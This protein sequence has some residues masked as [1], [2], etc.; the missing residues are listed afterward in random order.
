VRILLGF[1]QSV[2]L[3]IAGWRSRDSSSASRSHPGQHARRPVRAFTTTVIHSRCTDSLH[4]RRLSAEWKR[5]QHQPSL[6]FKERSPSAPMRAIVFLRRLIGT[7]RHRQ[8]LGQ[9]RYCPRSALDLLSF[10]QLRPSSRRARRLSPWRVWADSCG[11]SGRVRE[12]VM[13]RTA[14]RMFISVAQALVTGSSAR[15]LGFASW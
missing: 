5:K 4:L 9:C 14:I 1:L 13:T 3:A 2:L 11:P 7:A 10:L 12:P 8:N 6:G 15:R